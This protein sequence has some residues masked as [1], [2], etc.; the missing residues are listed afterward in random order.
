MYFDKVTVFVQKDNGN[1]YH[2]F[3]L[4]LGYPADSLVYGVDGEV[5]EFEPGV[6][7]LFG[8]PFSKV[9]LR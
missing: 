2:M 9:Y 6:Q 8:T 3:I 1:P 4:K 7:Q 5:V